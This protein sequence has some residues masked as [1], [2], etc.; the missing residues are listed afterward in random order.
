M[1]HQH[2]ESSFQNILQS[3]AAGRDKRNWRNCVLIFFERNRISGSAFARIMLT[4]ETP[5]RLTLLVNSTQ[6]PFFSF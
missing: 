1:C 2:G 3:S 6:S 5:D 4:Y